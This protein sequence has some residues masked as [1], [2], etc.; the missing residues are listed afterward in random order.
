MATARRSQWS[1]WTM[2]TS[3]TAK[4][5]N[6]WK[7]S[8]KYWGTGNQSIFYCNVICYSIKFYI[9]LRFLYCSCTLNYKFKPYFPHYYNL[10]FFL[11][12]SG[13]EG[14]YPDLIKFC[15][16]HLEKLDPRSRALMRE[17]P[18][19]TATSIQEDE[20][21]QIMDELMVC[22]VSTILPTTCWF[23]ERINRHIS[24]RLTLFFADLGKRHENGW[25]VTATAAT[26]CWRKYATCKR[27]QL[28]CFIL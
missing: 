8:W 24:A 21:H 26:V 15:E 19:A 2:T 28:F 11:K 22:L 1:T 7:R 6:T 27:F 13:D 23:T 16:T 4:M 17:N 12:R 25:N 3:E 20:W 9:F 18:V 5:L 14:I 10:L